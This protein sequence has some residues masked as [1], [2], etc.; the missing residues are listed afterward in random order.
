M[1]GIFLVSKGGVLLQ[2]GMKHI[3]LP[4]SFFVTDSRWYDRRTTCCWTSLQLQ[5]REHADLV[6]RSVSS[7]TLG[8]A[9]SNFVDDLQ[10]IM[11]SFFCNTDCFVLLGSRWFHT[12]LTVLFTIFV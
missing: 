5:T 11:L 9:T 8:L 12:P 6:A 1:F 10:Y 7:Q 2:T 3:A 4:C